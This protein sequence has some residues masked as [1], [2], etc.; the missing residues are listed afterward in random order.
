MIFYCSGAQA[1]PPSSALDQQEDLK[2]KAD[3][4]QNGMEKHFGFDSQL[5]SCIHITVLS[6]DLATALLLL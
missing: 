5:N 6:E 3:N 2:E 1:V 4:F